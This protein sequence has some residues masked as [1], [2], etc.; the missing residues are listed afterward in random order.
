MERIRILGAGV[1]GLTAAITLAKAGYEVEVYEKNRDVGMRFHGDLEGLENWSEKK[2]VV[3]EI[4]EM[5]IE[6][7]FDCDRFSAFT[8]TNFEKSVKI[9]TEKPHCYLVKRGPYPGT[10]DYGLREQAEKT[11]TVIHYG[12]TLPVQ[13]VEIAATG[14]IP[15]KIFG[16]VKGMIFKTDVQ[17]TAETIVSEEAACRGYSYLL[18]VK[19]YGCMGTVVFRDLPKV[20]K[21][22]ERTRYYYI[23]K[24]DLNPESVRDVGGVGSFLLRK[25]Y[26][27]GKTLCVGE[28]AGLQDFLYGFG[29]RY[30]LQSGYLAA[31]CIME[32]R[33]YEREATKYFGKKNRACIVNRFLWEITEKHYYRF[34][35]ENSKFIMNNRYHIY[36]FSLPQKILYPLAVIYIKKNYPSL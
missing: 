23:N 4:R 25:N 11:G 24:Y 35:I 22:F 18:I 19:G 7:N 8:L 33:D 2:D 20:H 27:R 30:A 1:S 14:P 16:A 17:D 31:K 32:G 34:V 28:A 13:D 29:M 36:N 5:G 6:L 9:Q 26:R 3:E 21:C 12:K 10:L 15:E